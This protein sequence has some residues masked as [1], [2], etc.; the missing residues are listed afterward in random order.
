METLIIKK[1]IQ[2]RV[3]RHLME[4]GGGGMD[5]RCGLPTQNSANQPTGHQII[6]GPESTYNLAAESKLAGDECLKREV[7]QLLE[8]KW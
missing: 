7:Q 2:L 4:L 3:F 6:R 1:C 8:D 5:L